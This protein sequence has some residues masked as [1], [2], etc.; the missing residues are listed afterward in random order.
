M[1]SVQ[2]QEKTLRVLLV[3]DTPR[4]Q[5]L[6]QKVF[7]DHAWI[8]VHTAARA[9]R[10]LTV[11]NFDLIMLD[12][13]LAGKEKGEDVALFISQSRNA[14]AK[15]IVHSMNFQKAKRIVEVLPQ[16]VLVP[17]SKMTRDNATIRRLRLELSKGVEIDWTFVF[18]QNQKLESRA[19]VT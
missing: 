14:S 3:E 2:E 4:R 5:K 1:N 13:D 8:T 6:L 10:F 18:G 16:A 12:F 11:Y 17:L 15:I 19:K 7:R 9:I